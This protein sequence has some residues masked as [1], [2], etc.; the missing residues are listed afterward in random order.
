MIDWGNG[1]GD[2]HGKWVKTIDFP[3]D[4][5]VVFT[6]AYNEQLI[7]EAEADCCSE[8]WFWHT[9][10][11]APLVGRTVMGSR[12]LEMPEWNKAVHGASRQDMDQLYGYEIFYR[13]GSVVLEFRNSSNGYYGGSLRRV[14]AIPEEAT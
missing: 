2:L 10:N 4:Q 8:S 6:V 9:E 12:E 13:G 14:S 3:D 7:Y 11:M 5:H 1:L